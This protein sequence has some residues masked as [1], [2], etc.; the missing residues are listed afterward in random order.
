M[1]RLS[2][3]RSPPACA[4]SGVPEVG[5][6]QQFAAAFTLIPPG[7]PVIAVGAGSLHVTIRQEAAVVFAVELLHAALGDETRL[8]HFPE[9]VLHHLGL[10]RAAGTTEM[11]EF[12][13]EPP[14]NIP[15]NRMVPIAQLP[16]THALFEGPGF[17]GGAV[18]VGSADIEGFIPVLTA[19]SGENIRG[20]HLNEIAEMRNIVHVGKRGG[21]KAPFHRLRIVR[22]GHGGSQSEAAD[23]ISAGPAGPGGKIFLPP[24]EITNLRGP[25]RRP[26][27]LE[28]TP[29]T[30]APGIPHSRPVS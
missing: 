12:N 9:K 10:H 15:M 4:A 18:F 11:I 26:S 27:F 22:S 3:H 25:C 8:V 21:Y 29:L 5:G 19:E 30:L 14:V 28:L 20:E 1:I 2:D 16:G 24:N 23:T 6:I 13:F 17:G 7:I